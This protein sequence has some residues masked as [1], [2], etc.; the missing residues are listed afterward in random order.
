MERVLEG[1]LSKPELPPPPLAGQELWAI[2][3]PYDF[4][5]T[6]WRS[7]VSAIRDGQVYASRSGNTNADYLYALDPA[8]GS[9][10]WRSEDLIDEGSTESL[11]FAPNGDLIGGNFTSLLRIDRVDGRGDL[12]RGLRDVELGSTTC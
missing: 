5:G 12:P 9:I 7:R 11:A 6:S 1:W 2:Q 3:L 4:P 8:D 10:V